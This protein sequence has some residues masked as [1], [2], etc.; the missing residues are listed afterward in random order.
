MRRALTAIFLFVSACAAQQISLVRNVRDILRVPNGGTGLGI[1]ADNTMLVSNGTQYTVVSIPNCPDTGGNHLNFVQSSKTMV[2][3]NSGGGGGGVTSF[4]GRTGAVIPATADYSYPQISGDTISLTRS[5]TFDS[6]A[7]TPVFN[8]QL[9]VGA[10]SETMRLDITGIVAKRPNATMGAT[11]VPSNATVYEAN[12]ISGLIENA[13]PI[14][15]AVAGSFM[16]GI[17]AAPPTGTCNTSGITVTR[18]SGPSFNTAWANI[19]NTAFNVN[20]TDYI[21]ASVIDGDT[22]TLTGSAGVQSGVSWARRVFVWGINSLVTDGLPGAVGSPSYD[23]TYLTNEFDFDAHHTTTKIFAQTITGAST[24]QPDTAYGYTVNYLGPAVKWNCG[25]C[26]LDG[27]TDHAMQ[28]GRT[29]TGNNVPSQHIL[30]FSR[31]SGGNEF[32]A[33]IRADADGN[34]VL[35]PGVLIPS[36]GN[37][38]TIMRDA[39]GNIV[40]SFKGSN[41][42]A[43]P[44]LEMASGAGIQLGAK[45]FLALGTPSNGTE[46]YCSDC[47]KATPCTSGGSGAFAKRING[48]WDCD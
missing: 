10:D 21:I 8:G 38:Q 7:Y 45:T 4:N 24:V 17:S 1:T 29:G 27:T 12:G 48:A 16:A 26:T 32:G 3:G 43:T 28:V 11:K 5:G 47:N 33:S 15:N 40:A 41:G 34:L 6:S 20:G 31:S 2:C 39:A 18:V 19:S 46:Y 44:S 25:F 23:W 14:T 9:G 35:N 36:G 37:P 42:G 13:S 30:M 22:L